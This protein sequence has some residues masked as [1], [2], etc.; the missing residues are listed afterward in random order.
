ME[1]QLLQLVRLTDDLLDVARITQ[2]KLELR[3]E[4]IDLRAVLHGAVER[5][6]R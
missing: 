6:G 4:R 2:D 1:R 5:R 3:R